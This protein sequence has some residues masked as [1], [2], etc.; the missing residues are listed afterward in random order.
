M[1][2]EPCGSQRCSWGYRC[3][4]R[5]HNPHLAPHRPDQVLLTLPQMPESWVNEAVPSPGLSPRAVPSP[6]LSP[7]PVGWICR[8]QS[9]GKLPALAR[10]CPAVFQPASSEQE[11]KGLQ[12]TL[13]EGDRYRDRQMGLCCSSGR[14]EGCAAAS[15][16]PDEGQSP[17]V[18][19]HP[20]APCQ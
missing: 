18:L 3:S 2:E 17:A 12:V 4:H 9:Q 16:Q 6:G 11:M 19:G 8:A 7:V 10:P 1:G 14:A 15:S 5:P 13:W 20:T